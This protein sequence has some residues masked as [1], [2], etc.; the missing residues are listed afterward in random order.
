MCVGFGSYAVST[1]RAQA[2][3]IAICGPDSLLLLL[4]GPTQCSS[5]H[6]QAPRDHCTT[7]ATT[8]GWGQQ[9]WAQ[10]LAAQFA[11]ASRES[12]PSNTY[13]QPA[14]CAIGS[15]PLCWQSSCMDEPCCSLARQSLHY[16][17]CRIASGT[18]MGASSN[19]QLQAAAIMQ[20]QTTTMQQPAGPTTTALRQLQSG[21]QLVQIIVL[22]FTSSSMTL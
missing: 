13:T 4:V 20:Q 8:G 5:S 6:W 21:M 16:C 19:Q 14:M 11:Y 3:G 10:Q 1:S 18:V 12:A 7:E 17:A 9:H 22:A 2:Q 15:Q